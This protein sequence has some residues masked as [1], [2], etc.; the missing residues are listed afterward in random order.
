MHSKNARSAT[1]CS[2]CF[3]GAWV[4]FSCLW[5]GSTPTGICVH[6]NANEGRVLNWRCY[7]D[8]SFCIKM[9]DVE[10]ELT[11]CISFICMQIFTVF[12]YR[13]VSTVFM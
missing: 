6:Y 4:G 9:I 7:L 12:K 1:T 11:V 5:V 8:F 3:K 2:F 13:I 10:L